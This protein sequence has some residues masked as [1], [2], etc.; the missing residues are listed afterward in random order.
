MDNTRD[1]LEDAVARMLAERVEPRGT[2]AAEQAGIDA[3]TWAQLGLIGVTG[4]EAARMDFGTQAVVLKATAY[5]G[6]LVPYADSEVLGRWLALGAGLDCV[7]EVLA[8]KVLPATACRFESNSMRLAVQGQRVPWGRYAQQVL[9]SVSTQGCSFVAA[10]P[11]A[12]LQ[13]R[14]GANLAAEPH[15]FAQAVFVDVAAENVREISAGWS[16]EAVMARGALCRAV[17]MQGAMGRVNELT[18]RYA[19][20]RKQFGRALAQFQVVQSYLA[21]MA[22]ELCAT[23]AAA[24]AATAAIDGGVRSEQEIAAV[25]VRAGQAA[26]VVV[27]HGHQVHGAIGFTR[28]FPLNLWTRRLWAWREEYGSESHWARRLGAAVVARGADA[29]WPDLTLAQEA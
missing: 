11:S 20:E 23:E 1:M 2:L 3:D 16:P 27:A 24:E 17:Q 26:R 12:V 5:S 19:H 21:A 10:V 9:F 18:L 4:T 29:L 7:D 8:V 6:A 14:P 22:S 25:K 28:E 15:D 13:L